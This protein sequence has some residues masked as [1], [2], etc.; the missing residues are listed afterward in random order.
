MIED[1]LVY[2]GITYD[3]TPEAEEAQ[4]SLNRKATQKIM[5]KLKS[6]ILTCDKKG[7]SGEFTDLDHYIRHEIRCKSIDCD[8]DEVYQKL[9]D[10]FSA[11][12]IRSKFK[13]SECEW[14]GKVFEDKNG[15]GKH[16]LKQHQTR[17]KNAGRCVIGYI[18]AKLSTLS[19]SEA[20]EIKELI[21]N[22]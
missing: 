13:F 22:M 15:R 16:L 3:M 10:K 2:K 21:D 20:L 9:E 14:C 1:I 7:C 12:S 4:E 6:P 18:R 17:G 19:T 11:T 8:L 5:N